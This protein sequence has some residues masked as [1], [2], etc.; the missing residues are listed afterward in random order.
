VD[1]SDALV[2]AEI[3]LQVEFGQNPPCDSRARPNAAAST[4]S[5]ALRP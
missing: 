2:F 1:L 3:I 5:R 4:A